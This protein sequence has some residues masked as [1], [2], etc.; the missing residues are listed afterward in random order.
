MFVEQIQNLD[1]FCAS[2]RGAARHWR[3]MVS[4]GVPADA[5]ITDVTVSTFPDGRHLKPQ[6]RKSKSLTSLGLSIDMQSAQR[7]NQKIQN[8]FCSAGLYTVSG[9]LQFYEKSL[10]LTHL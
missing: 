5:L 2:G 7:M 8:R 6:N 1:I 4:P 10:L 3:A 9:G